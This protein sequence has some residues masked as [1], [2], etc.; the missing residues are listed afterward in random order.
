[1]SYNLTGLSCIPLRAEKFKKH[2]H[3]WSKCGNQ[4]FG[5]EGFE[6]QMASH[7]RQYK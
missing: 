7:F 1:M 6:P 4:C 5:P 2:G 3:N